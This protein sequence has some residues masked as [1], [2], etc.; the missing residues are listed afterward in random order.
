VI[1]LIRRDRRWWECVRHIPFL[2]A[3]MDVRIDPD[4][5]DGDVTDKQRQV[6]QTIMG[7]PAATQA[8]MEAPI[9]ANYLK[10]RDEVE[11]DT[12]PEIATAAAIWSHLDLRAILIPRHRASK[13]SYFF[14]EAECTWEPEHGLEV[15]FRDG[16]VLQVTQQEG[17]A[18]NQGW[19]LRYINE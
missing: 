11:D 18:S 19:S 14:V 17:L 2:D 7:L 12:M 9:F 4:Q 10:I 1:G 3:T 16:G 13:Y 15:L 5:R 8:L 6:Y